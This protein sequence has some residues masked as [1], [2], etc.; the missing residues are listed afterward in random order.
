MN[1]LAHS[2]R[3]IPKDGE[4]IFFFALDIRKERITFQDSHVNSIT[5]KKNILL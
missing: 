5:W 2:I 3:R 1:V 4:D